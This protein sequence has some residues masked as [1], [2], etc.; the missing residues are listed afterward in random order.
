VLP[1]VR[2]FAVLIGAYPIRSILGPA[3]QRSLEPLVATTPL[4]LIF[5]F[6]HSVRIHLRLAHSRAVNLAGPTAPVHC[7]ARLPVHTSLSFLRIRAC[8]RERNLASHPSLAR[9]YT[10]M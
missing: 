10:L 7:R 2:F 9:T 4:P 1:R 8:L 3:D 6:S 5:G